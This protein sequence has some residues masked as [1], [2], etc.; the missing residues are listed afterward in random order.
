MGVDQGSDYLFL[1]VSGGKLVNKKKEIA[2]YSYTGILVGIDRAMD[3][4]EGRDIPKIKLKVKDHKSDEVAQISFSE[5]SWYSSGF[6]ARI[7]EIDLSKPF[8]VGASGS[9]QNEKVSFCWLKQN[10]ETIK[11]EKGVFP[12]PTKDRRGKDNYDALVEAIDPIVKDLQNRLNNQKLET[13]G[14]GIGNKM[15]P[16]ENAYAKPLAGDT[17]DKGKIYENAS[18]TPPSDDLPF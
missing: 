2:A 17:K 4:Y 8:S 3:N 7:T 18:A 11:V 12:T 16:N 13:T 5:E 6:F 9:E 15:P 10:G 14:S 1:N